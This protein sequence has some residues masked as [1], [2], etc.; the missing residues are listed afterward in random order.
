[1]LYAFG[2]CKLEHSQKCS[3]CCQL[4]DLFDELNV[5]L[6]T[7]L[8]EQLEQYQDQLLYYLAHQTRKVYLNAQFK[9]SLLELNDDNAV[10]VAD[11][12]MKVLKKSTRET[13]EEF[14]GKSRWTLHIILV[15]QNSSNGNFNIQAYDHWSENRTQD[16]WFTASCFDAVFTMME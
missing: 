3:Q 13:K 10:I 12:K 2:D 16:A 6:G 5:Q 4:F 1:M 15:F 8:S 7:E 14:F 9:A 11:Y